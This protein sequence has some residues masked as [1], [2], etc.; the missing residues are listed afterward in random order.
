M[1]VC[2]VGFSFHMRRSRCSGKRYPHVEPSQRAIQQIKDHTRQ[3]TGR[4]RTPVPLP[5][6]I[7]E[8]NRVVRGWSNYFHHGNR[9]NVFSKVRWLVEERVRIQ[10]RRRHKLIR[11]QAYLRFSARRLYGEYGLYK[12]PASAPWRSAKAPV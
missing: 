11:A 9:T 1:F 2:N 6:M 10:L 8:V 4:R 5:V 12:V 7:N 3:L